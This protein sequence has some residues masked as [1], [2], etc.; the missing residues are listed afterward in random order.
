MLFV[1]VVTP[2]F[3]KCRH[4]NKPI[5][6]GLLSINIIYEKEKEKKPATGNGSNRFNN[7][8]LNKLR[9]NTPIDELSLPGIFNIKGSH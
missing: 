5:F 2:F 3:N 1:L 7:K 9:T 8:S 6:P 4:D